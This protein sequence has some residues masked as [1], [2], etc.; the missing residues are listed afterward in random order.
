MREIQFGLKI[1]FG[2]EVTSWKLSKGAGSIARRM[3]RFPF[4]TK[5][6]ISSFMNQHFSKAGRR[7]AG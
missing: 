5:H 2:C 1:V 7:W 4:L 6:D 3:A